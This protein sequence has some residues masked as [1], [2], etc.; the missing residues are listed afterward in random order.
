[1]I[2]YA[3]LSSILLG[4]YWVYYMFFVKHIWQETYRGM[5][6]RWHQT[7]FPFK[8]RLQ[9]AAVGVGLL[10]AFGYSLAILSFVEGGYWFRGHLSGWLDTALFSSSI[11]STTLLLLMSAVAGAVCV[12]GPLMLYAS[13][14]RVQ[15]RTSIRS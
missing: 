1:M 11:L 15:S 6:E 7:G 10:Y 9:F 5:C 14:C 13:I 2:L 12:I 4:M 8:K 3:I